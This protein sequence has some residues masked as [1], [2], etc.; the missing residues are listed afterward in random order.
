MTLTI[1]LVVAAGIL[2]V[3]LKSHREYLRLPKLPITENAETGDVTVIIPARNEEKTIAAAVGSF[4][5]RAKVLV[6][7]DASTDRTAELARAAG[8]TVIPA[9]PLRRGIA[10]KPNACAA[11]AKTAESTWLLF[12]DADTEFRP[13][14]LPSLM[15]EVRRSSLDMAS[16]FLKQEYRSFWEAIV[17]P[18]AVAVSFAAV[19][20]RKVNAKKTYDA[21]ASGQCMLFRREVYNFMGGHAAVATSIID[22][23]ML[24][25]TA[26]RHRINQQVMRAEHLGTGRRTEGFGGVWRWFE[27]SSF[28]FVLVSRWSAVQVLLAAILMSCY[29][30]V[31]CLLVYERRRVLASVFASIPPVVLAPW[32]GGLHRSILAPIAIYAFDTIGFLALIGT[33]LGRRTRWKGR[34]V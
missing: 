27:Q 34:R 8:A 13:E 32:Y 1:A 6:V 25:Y 15:A 33:A 10:P 9:P 26:K 17:V 28:R 31:V 16:V 19:N 20:T 22:D 21:I 11:G 24:A 7:D 3:L 18:Y 12:V 4:A 14:F 30:P 5:A 29:A 23:A 2:T